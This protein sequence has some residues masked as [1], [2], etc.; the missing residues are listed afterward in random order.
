MCCRTTIKD[1]V[2][3]RHYKR[4]CYESLQGERIRPLRLLFAKPFQAMKTPGW[5]QRAVLGR[6]RRA[7]RA[8]CSPDYPQLI[9]FD[10]PLEP[11]SDANPVEN[12]P[13]G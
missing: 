2:D 6:N 11:E 9:L 13:L 12:C 10:K 1:T 3:R 8:T 4:L 5:V 7:P